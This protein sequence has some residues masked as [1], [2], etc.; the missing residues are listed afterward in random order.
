VIALN[1]REK[2]SLFDEQDQQVVSTIASQAATALVNAGLYSEAR[3]EI[4]AVKQLN[5]LGIAMAA[6]Q[7]RINNTFNI[8]IPNV[9]RLRSRVDVKDPTIR[10]IL[11]IIERNARYTSE[12][13]KRI[14]DPL[15]EVTFQDLNVNT[16]IQDV[17]TRLERGWRSDSTQPFCKIFLELDDSA[18]LIRGSSGQ[19]AEVFNN[20]LDNAHKAMP[21]G[22]EIH[23]TTS[24]N[25]G[26]I[27]SR[28]RDSGPGIPASI[29]ERLFNKPV[30]SSEPGSGAGLG[31]W[32]SRLIL[33]SI[34][35]DISIEASD[36]SGTTMCVVVPVS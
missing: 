11:E 33:Q 36:T 9:E 28:V 27:Y 15:K 30:P 24:L 32:L 35:G 7:H 17:A 23:V 3:G 20:L 14:Q 5:I 16:I 34:G 8:I 4:M 2:E 12:I 6:L 26:K 18:P 22:G 31:L 10:E 1:H 21:M 13:V 25:N 29:Q 19:I